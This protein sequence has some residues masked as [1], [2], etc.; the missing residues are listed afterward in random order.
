MSN[1]AQQLKQ[2]ANNANNI[3]HQIEKIKIVLT[4][5]AE[6][7]FFEHEIRIDSNVI[8]TMELLKAEGL[9]VK[10][11]ETFESDD[12]IINVKW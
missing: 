10:I 9:D 3:Q 5:Q 6:L 11:I 2:L 7:G 12:V 4:Q 8:R 1:F